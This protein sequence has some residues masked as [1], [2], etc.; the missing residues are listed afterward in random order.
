M[1]ARP[2]TAAKKPANPKKPLAAKKPASKKKVAAK[3]K[4]VARKKA[5]SPKKSAARPK[6]ASRP[7]TSA[8][9]LAGVGSEAVKKATGKAWD[10]WLVLLDK[11]GAAK[12][13]HKAIAE[14]VYEKWSVP[15]WWGQ[16]V[17]VGYEQ[18]RGLRAVNQK[19]DGYAASASKTFDA[20]LERVYAAWKDPSQRE[21]WLPSAP[22]DVRRST[23]GKSMRI[24]WTLG[25]SNVE[26]NFSSAGA[27]KSKVQVEH[28]KLADPKEVA[29]Q[30]KYWREGLERLKAMV[31]LK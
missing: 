1:A 23:D 26:V 31:E 6:K 15:P 4:A 20:A 25:D 2:K 24:T 19:L 18:A 9:K 21:K 8:M 22:L 5:P 7:V 28:G 13:P 12:M 11:A 27:S 14:M 17:T 10:Q 3:P 30:K 16:M 29:A